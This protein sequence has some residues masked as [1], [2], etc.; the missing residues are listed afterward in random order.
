MNGTFTQFLSINC[1]PLQ[2]TFILRKNNNR[3]R[4]LNNTPYKPLQATQFKFILQASAFYFVLLNSQII[5]AFSR[6][7]FEFAILLLISRTTPGS[8]HEIQ[9]KASTFNE[10]PETFQPAD[11]L[12]GVQG[13][14]S[15]W[16][17][18]AQGTQADERHR[19]QL[20]CR[21]VSR[22]C[23]AYETTCTRPRVRVRGA[24]GTAEKP[25]QK[26]RRGQA[27]AW[28]G[29]AR[30]R[31]EKAC[32]AGFNFDPLEEEISTSFIARLFAPSHRKGNV[33]IGIPFIQAPEQIDPSRPTNPANPSSRRSDPRPSPRIRSHHHRLTLVI[34]RF[35]LLT[36][37]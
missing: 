15:E 7:H 36:P 26:K 20:Q 23:L 14:G 25:F 5:Q 33:I 17:Y 9:R 6:K 35:I 16:R 27:C 4:N 31:G 18:K 19:R 8:I 2:T 37:Y 12:R 28:R 1:S 24:L 32:A 11:Y 10:S 30:R 13:T 3:L 22:R 29:V 34:S 21:L